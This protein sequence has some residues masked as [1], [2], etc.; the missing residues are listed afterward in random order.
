M[1]T[2]Q[3]PKKSKKK[4]REKKTRQKRE[5]KKKERDQKCIQLRMMLYPEEH[6]WTV[7]TFHGLYDDN[8]DY[9][10]KSSSERVFFSEIKIA[11]ILF[12]EFIGINI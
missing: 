3:W 11:K 5:E 2:E 1:N 8:D 12:R 6:F 7:P 10:G 4:T 9:N